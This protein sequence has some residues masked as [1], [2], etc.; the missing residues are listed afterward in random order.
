MGRLRLWLGV[1]WY[2]HAVLMNASQ[3]REMH[4]HGSTALA[5]GYLRNQTWKSVVEYSGGSEGVPR[6][7]W[8]P[9]GFS[10]SKKIIEV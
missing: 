1:V 2:P 5:K 3:G 4:P 9:S 7:P 6:V 10:C 8:S